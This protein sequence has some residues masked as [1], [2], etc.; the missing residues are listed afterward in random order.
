MLS[1]PFVIWLLGLFT[2]VPYSVYY[3]FF[4]ASRGQYAFLIA[5][6]LFWVFGYWTIVAPILSLLRVRKTLKTIGNFNSKEKM[7]ELI[8]SEEAKEAAIEMISSDNRIPQFL[9]RRVLDILIK[10]YQKNSS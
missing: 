4:E 10:S 9:A 3:L 2:V 7:E 6:A 1:A 5:F 8:K